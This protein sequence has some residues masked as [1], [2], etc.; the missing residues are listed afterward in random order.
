[1]S[2]HPEQ[3]RIWRQANLSATIEKNR[4]IG[5]D[6]ICCACC[7]VIILPAE[8]RAHTANYFERWGYLHAAC[9]RAMVLNISEEG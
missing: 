8:R 7:G 5:A 1:M 9:E 4:F 2:N 3:T 6:A